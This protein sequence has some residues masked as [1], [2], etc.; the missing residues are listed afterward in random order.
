IAPRLTGEARE[1]MAASA[2]L[3]GAANDPAPRAFVAG[4][5]MAARLAN[6]ELAP[7]GCDPRRRATA[8][9][10]LNGSLGDDAALDALSM[11]GWSAFAA[12]DAAAARAAWEKVVATRPEDLAAWEGLRSVGEQTGDKALRARAA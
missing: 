4:E 12:G 7:P 9:V 5:S 11:A 2:A 3:L 8:L 10:E 6:L 1:Q